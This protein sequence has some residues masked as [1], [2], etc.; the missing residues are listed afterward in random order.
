M[1]LP[2]HP[3]A[4]LFSARLSC[5]PVDDAPAVVLGPRMVNVCTALGAPLRDW[6]QVCEWASRLDDDRVRDTFG[7][8]VDVL[9]ADRCVRLGND[10]VSE[11]IV[12]EVDGDGLT[13]DE[14]RTLLVD[15]VQAATQPV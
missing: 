5:A 6:W 7:A 2:S 8:Y 1:N 9:V 13:A 12:H 14:I 4:E 10:L 11:L 3:L 15:F